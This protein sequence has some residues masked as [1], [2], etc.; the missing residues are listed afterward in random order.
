M[1]TEE[2]I[3]LLDRYYNAETTPREERLLRDFFQGDDVPEALRHEKALFGQ[4]YAPAPAVPEGMETRLNR[5]IEAWNMV[6][7]SGKRK[8]RNDSMRWM[9]GMAASLLLL[10]TLGFYLNNRESTAAPYT[11]GKVETYDNP[12]DAMS[13]TERVLTKFSLAINKGLD[14]MNNDETENV[15]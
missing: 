12:K 8:A 14:K 7:K 2:I 3:L 4:L 5:A 9:I 11:A 13:E 15:Q 10:C 6:E 1:T